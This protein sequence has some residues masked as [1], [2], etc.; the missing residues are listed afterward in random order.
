MGIQV[1]K[2]EFSGEMEE[3][4]QSEK[5]LPCSMKIMKIRGHSQS[6]HKGAMHSHTLGPSALEREN[7]Q[8]LLGQQ[9]FP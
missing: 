4:S 9:D 2:N 6:L 3:L 7:P 5:Y 1:M 8:G